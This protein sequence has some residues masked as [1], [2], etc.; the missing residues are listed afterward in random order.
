MLIEFEVGNYRSFK[1]PVRLSMVAANPIKEA[2]DINTFQAGHDGRYRLLKSAVIYGANAS[3]K[4]NLLEAMSFMRL[5]VLTSLA[6]MQVEEKIRAKPFKLDA[7]TENA[8]SHFEITFL[9]NN[10]RYR[11]GFEVDKNAVRKEWLFRAEK[12]K[13]DMLFIRENADIEI[14]DNFKEGIG[15]EEKTR[16]SAPFLSVVAQFNGEI[17]GSILKWFRGFK[18]LHAQRDQLYERFSVQFLQDETMRPL[19]MDLIHKADLGIDDLVVDEIPVDENAQQALSGLRQELRK[20][21]TFRISTVH[22]KFR[23]GVKEGNAQLNLFSEGSEGTAKIVRIA[24]P[25]L[26]CLKN[27][28]VVA[29]DELDAKLHPL[30]TK[31]IVRL[32]NSSDS[33]PKNAQLIFTTHDTNLLQDVQGRNLRRDQIWFTEKNKH[34]AT[35]LYSLA[36]MKA[37]ND[38]AIE[39]NYIQGRYGAIPFLGD[40]GALLKETG[41]GASSKTE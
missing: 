24:G 38:A 28:H 13:E 25:L 6:E 40:F 14:S 21:R 29:V 34:S 26:D 11:Y 18:S 39:K 36:E 7:V 23:D 37:R 19:I 16:D 22:Q 10:S 20:H 2:L 4:S 17:A 32:F 3:G 41:D 15:L 27:G 31:A 5:F 8:P 33:N 1:E 35:D 9:H 12:V 30:L